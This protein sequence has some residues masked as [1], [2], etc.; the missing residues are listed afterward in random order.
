[1]KS[2]WSD[3]EAASFLGDLQQRVYTSRLLG[4]ETSL[5]LHGGGNTSVKSRVTNLFGE[6]EEILYVKGSGWD[7]E[8]IEAQGFSP[9]RMNHLLRLAKL[10]ALSD[11]Q[12]AV[13]LKKSLTDVSAPMPSVEAILHAILPARFVDHTHADA[14]LA[15]TNSPDGESRVRDLFGDEL[16]YIPYVMPG[17]KLARS[18]A[19]LYPLHAGPDTIGMLLLNHGLFT[20]GETAKIAYERMTELVSRAERYLA[21]HKA[22]STVSL[23]GVNGGDVLPAEFKPKR[24]D[25]AAL[26]KAVSD[27]A[28]APMILSVHTDADALSF[29]RRPDLCE[30]SQQGPA[31]P[32]HVIRTK[33]V[34]LIGRNV[35]AYVTAYRE[36]FSKFSD[37][38][39]TMLDPAPRVILDRELGLCCIGR[40]AKDVGIVEDIYRHTM[41]IQ[42][43][44]SALGGWRALPPRDIFEVEYWD[45]EQAKLRK[46]GSLPLF[47]GEIALVTGAAS[48]IGKAAVSSLLSRGAAVVGLDIS[49]TVVAL[50][51]RKDYFGI[52]CDLTREEGI[53][54]ALEEGVR[55]YGGLDMLVLNAG[56]FPNSVPIASLSTDAW[57]KA[58]SINLDSNLV[59]M[60]ECH[61]LL[62]LSPR[63]GRV[64]FIGSKNVAAPG[65]GAAAYSAS[66]AALQ[67]MARV[68]ALEW[69]EDRIR[70]NTLH[71]NAVFDTGIWTP[72]VLAARAASC[73]MTVEEYKT[74]N[75][76]KVEI[77]SKQVADLAAELCGPTFAGTTGAQIPIDGGNE[78]VI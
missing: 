47:N 37:A 18:C 21:E 45:L 75:V 77:S 49:P 69:G 71:P 54:R 32:D 5:V 35:G 22:W 44:A 52:Q 25:I 66:K 20:F 78:R 43:Q 56:V 36:Y 9:C 8:T 57:R 13:E 2:R 70:I 28:G 15:M 23:G 42:S 31:T 38:S 24:A 19:E 26:R 50:H 65:R 40:T 51:K 76:L 1:V 7:L 55:A 33:R 74:N 58:M 68:A 30:I 11:S 3:Q 17:F 72:E 61:P 16:V 4:A 63:G 62:K 46:S 10:K 67:Q 6:E 41:E 73:R 53:G 12:M 27:A 59:L 48:G 60:R 64:V 29:A 34:P 14:I 39:V